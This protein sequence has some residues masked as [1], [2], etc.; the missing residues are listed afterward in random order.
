MPRWNDIGLIMLEIEMKAWVDDREAMLKRLGEIASW[1]HDFHK[2]D[3]YF[4]VKSAPDVRIRTNGDNPALLTR[5]QKVMIDG[6][7][8]NTE[9]EYQ[10]GDADAFIQL[11]RDIGVKERLRK[12]KIGSA[13]RYKDLLIEL[14]TVTGLG[15]FVE[16]EWVGECANRDE[17]IA[18]KDKLYA[19][20][21]LLGI[22][23]LDIEPRP[24]SY[25]L[26]HIPRVIKDHTERCQCK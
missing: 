13:Y 24:Y 11:M 18:V 21:E 20:A 2:K 7:E 4:K 16:I 10:V 6:V 3:V 23:S 12:E 1:Q 25:M 9:V 5:K 26:K 19:F 14:S 17:Q 15:C 8:I 22:N